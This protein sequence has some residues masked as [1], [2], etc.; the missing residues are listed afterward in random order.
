MSDS[1]VKFVSNEF[2]CDDSSV[3]DAEKLLLLG[4][5]L[6]LRVPRSST[7]DHLTWVLDRISEIRDCVNPRLVDAVVITATKR[8]REQLVL[9]LLSRNESLLYKEPWETWSNDGDLLHLDYDVLP[10]D[11][12]LSGQ[13]FTVIFLLSEGL[14]LGPFT[15]I[16]YPGPVPLP[17]L[18]T[19]WV[20]E[21]VDGCD[22]EL[23]EN[24]S[25]LL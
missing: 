22:P 15:G 19:R 24:I 23:A 8:L 21:V 2:S 11:N 9:L 10:G 13:Q 7:G 16:A 6:Q 3:D 18:E 4:S 12:Y 1:K 17:L 14:R 20:L 25:R 5:L